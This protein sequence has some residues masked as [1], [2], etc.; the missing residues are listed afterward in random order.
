[1]VLGVLMVRY[2]P[3]PVLLCLVFLG[4]HYLHSCFTGAIGVKYFVSFLGVDSSSND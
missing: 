4:K 1:M 2:V 3:S